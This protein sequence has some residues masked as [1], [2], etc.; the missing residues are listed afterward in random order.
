MLLGIA[1]V[2]FEEPQVP[3]DMDDV[4][5]R[6]IPRAWR[7]AAL[8]HCKKGREASMTAGIL[9]DLGTEAPIRRRLRS[10]QLLCEFPPLQAGYAEVHHGAGSG[11]RRLARA[12]QQHHTSRIALH[13]FIG[14]ISLGVFVFSLA[15]R[16]AGE[17][18]Y[19]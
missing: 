6:R 8:I 10:Q 11:Q 2:S 15:G 3:A 18:Q 9:C 13:S 17:A 7:N 14:K 19:R 5:K 16:P 4:S 12:A 1:Q